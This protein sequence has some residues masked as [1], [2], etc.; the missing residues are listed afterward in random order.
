MKH[1]ILGA[2]GSIGKPL[3]S[4][5][6][7]AGEDVRLVSRTVTPFEGAEIFKADL[8]SPDEVFAAVRNS[9]VV[10]LLAGLPYNADIWRE[11]WPLVMKNT[12]EA[13]KAAGSRLIFLDNV[14]MYGKVDGIMTEDTPYRPCSKKG[15]IRA[16]IATM[17]Q[18]EMGKDGFQATIARSADF[19]GPYATSNSMPYLFVFE[20]YLNNKKAQWMLDAERT[21]SYTYT[22]DC[23]RGLK[24]LAENE[25]CYNQVWHLPTTN[26]APNGRE[27]I[28]IAA[29]ILGRYPAYSVMGKGMLK[30]GSVFSRM[31]KEV[32]EMSYQNEYPYVFDSEKFTSRFAYN[33]VSYEEGIRETIEF[34]RKE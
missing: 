23:A 14:Y 32:S 28:E 13:T 18:D 12:I 20:K 22:V 21:H 4:E 1:T 10:Y 3:A 11:K 34:L 6:I 25:D 27:F 15:E 9:D 8:Y 7:S 17:L 16:Q 31:V 19:Y 33:S 30:M 29:H 26:P 24:I 2:G 5:L